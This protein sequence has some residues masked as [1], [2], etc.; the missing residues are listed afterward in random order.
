MAKLIA[1]FYINNHQYNLYAHC[2]S[3][4]FNA[5][6][7][8]FYHLHDSDTGQCLTNNCPYYNFP[9]YSDIYEFITEIWKC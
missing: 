6:K 3:D 2:N 8:R 9:L 5:Y 7:I 1:S 4:D